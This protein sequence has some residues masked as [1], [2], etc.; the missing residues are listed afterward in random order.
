MAAVNLKDLFTS[1]HEAV[2]NASNIGRNKNIKDLIDFF[3]E[4]ADGT[5]S[6]KLVKLKMQDDKVVDVPLFVLAQ[7]NSI[8]IDELK[9]TFNVEM[10]ES[11]N[12][13][14]VQPMSDNDDRQSVSKATVEIKFKGNQPTEGFMRINDHLVFQLPK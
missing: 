1:I 9:M 14:N 3:E 5:I 7:H 13:I 4:N 11:E 12:N 8:G 6:P 2:S 10:S